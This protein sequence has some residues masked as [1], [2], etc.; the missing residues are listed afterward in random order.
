MNMYTNSKKKRIIVGVIV[1]LLV[2]SMVLPL[3]L[4]AL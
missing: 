2:A 3:V 1:V 4:S